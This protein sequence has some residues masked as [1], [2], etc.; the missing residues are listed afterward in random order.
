MESPLESGRDRQGA[1]ARLGNANKHG[2]FCQAN[3]NFWPGGGPQSV[4][5]SLKTS[6]AEL[7]SPTTLKCGMKSLFSKDQ[8]LLTILSQHS[9]SKNLF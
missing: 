5:G 7:P 3:Y 2:G 6:P 4:W 9:F 1:H 8:V